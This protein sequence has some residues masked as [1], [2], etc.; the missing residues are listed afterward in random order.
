MERIRVSDIGDRILI[1]GRLGYPLGDLVTI[2]GEWMLPEALQ[3]GL[4]SKDTDLK[5]RVTTV[6]GNRLDESILIPVMWVSPII[7]RQGLAVTPKAGD[8]WEARGIESGRFHGIPR[9]VFEELYPPHKMIPQRIDKFGFFTEFLY[10]SCRIVPQ[11]PP[12]KAS[13]R[14]PLPAQGI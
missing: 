11:R 1:V 13:S 14:P 3:R 2:E 5:L 4:Q 8:V 12:G 7:D 10:S 6:N 9:A